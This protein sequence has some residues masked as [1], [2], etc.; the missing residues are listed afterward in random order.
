[1]SEPAHFPSWLRQ[2]YERC[3]H[4]VPGAMLS[5]TIPIDDAALRVT[6]E[7]V[8][9]PDDVPSVALAA[10]DGYALRAADTATASRAEPVELDCELGLAPLA[11]RTAS[12][13][14]RA[15]APRRAASIPAYV[16][17][18]DH[19][20]TVAPK[21]EHRWID[22]NAGARLRFHAPL[23]A[24]QHVIA[25]GSEFRKG[26]VLLA[27]GMRITPA[28]QAVLIA[29]GVRDIAVTKRP[30]IGV[31]IAGY[32]SVPPG[33]AR[34]PWQ[35]FDSIGP[36]LRA[37]LRQWGYEV[38]AVETLPLPSSIPWSSEAERN[39]REF[40][41]RLGA[42]SGRYDL[43]VG[44]GLPAGA[45]FEIRGL[46]AQTMYSNSRETIRIQQTPGER[47]NAGRSDDRS[48]PT[49]WTVQS[50]RPDGSVCRTEAFVSYDQAVLVNLPGHTSGVAALMHTIV[51]RVLDLLEH[52]AAPGPC[53]A[54]ALTAHDIAPDAELNGMR[55]GN[56][57]ATERGEARVRLLPFQGDGPIRGIAEADGLVAIP[58]GVD[59]LPAGTPV[60]FLRLDGTGTRA[61]PTGVTPD[62]T[63][64]VAAQPLQAAPSPDAPVARTATPD[65]RDA[66]KRIGHAIAAHPAS[67]P[68]GLNGPADEHALAELHVALGSTLPD[69]VIDSLRL[70]DGQA[71]PD[72]VFT[73]SD[74]L[75]SAQEIVAQ[76]SIWQKLVSGGDFDGMTSEPDAGIRDDWYNL[77]W[78][79][80]TH[81]GSGNH[82]CIDLD[83]A[84]GGVIGQVIR[85]W[86]DDELRERVA[87]SYAEWL[88]RVAAERDSP[89]AA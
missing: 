21:T 16:A 35:R 2:A 29:A 73:E 17:M 76:W 44:A 78:I 65:V 25:V 69:D 66:W 57:S 50:T 40:K 32:D 70:H 67:L 27:K 24:G 31:V 7:D 39:E 49:K 37:V 53:W 33:H 42:L 11:S 51:P 23:A 36:Y 22:A 18:P 79:P 30:R 88:A 56:L 47:F 15:L 72:A 12:P 59:V 9:A 45:P 26:Q 28:R 87:S 86:H 63:A 58:A 13:A 8:I 3:R 5:E 6:A 77:K 64:K 74:A 89:A 83:P 80:F 71:D 1:M 81:D 61:S 20:D 75:L 43:I 34:E 60:L 41:Q 68:G 62:E 52:V 84:E 14:A 4:L 54:T 82:L 19:A 10:C 48:P 38:P 55:W 46:N 85:V